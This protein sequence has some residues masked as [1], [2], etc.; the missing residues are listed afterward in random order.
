MSVQ[1]LETAVTSLPDH[2]LQSFANWFEEYLADAW[3][4]QIEQD[5]VAG[6]LDRVGERANAEFESGNCTPL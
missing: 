3:D 1:E 6:K 4:R 2:E 5:I